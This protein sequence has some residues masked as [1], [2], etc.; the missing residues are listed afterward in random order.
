[1]LKYDRGRLGRK[2]TADKGFVSTIFAS[3]NFSSAHTP[4]PRVI[5]EQSLTSLISMSGSLIS[6]IYQGSGICLSLGHSHLT[7]L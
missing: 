1:M 2:L 3:V 7:S 4:P 5:A 6:I